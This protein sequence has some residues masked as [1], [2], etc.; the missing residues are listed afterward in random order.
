MVGGSPGG[1][2]L[3]LTRTRQPTKM[4]IMM[5]RQTKTQTTAFRRTN[6]SNGLLVMALM[7]T[8]Q[9]KVAMTCDSLEELGG[10][11]RQLRWPCD[12]EDPDAPEAVDDAGEEAQLTRPS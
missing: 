5:T 12:D 9:T 8:M 1:P 6:V 10:A 11:G 2:S 3:A 7:K 4:T